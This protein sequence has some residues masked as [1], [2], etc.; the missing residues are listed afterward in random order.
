MC[1]ASEKI[2]MWVCQGM[3]ELE[4]I[5]IS[6]IRDIIFGLFIDGKGMNCVQEVKIPYLTF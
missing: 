4:A 5:A 3:G 2:P 1:C 6:L